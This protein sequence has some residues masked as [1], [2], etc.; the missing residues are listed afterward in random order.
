LNQNY[1]EKENNKTQLVK[2]FSK[3]NK[4][5]AKEF[6]GSIFPFAA[7]KDEERSTVSGKDAP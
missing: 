3:I 6:D 4:E 5:T 1:I 7:G 2:E